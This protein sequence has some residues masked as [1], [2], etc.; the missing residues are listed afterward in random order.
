LMEHERITG[1]FVSDPYEAGWALEALAFVYVKSAPKEPGASLSIAV[2]LS[3]D[4]RRWLED[5]TRLNHLER[6]GAYLLRVRHFGN[7]LRLRGTV[8]GLP[9][10]GAFLVD[11][12]WVFKG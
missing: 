3:A 6:E 5:G 10:D 2:E 4:G 12:Y 1:G 8:E 9:E 11:I 7:W